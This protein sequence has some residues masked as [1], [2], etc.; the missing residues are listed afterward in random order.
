MMANGRMKWM[1]KN[2]VRVGSLIE[3]PPHNHVVKIVPIYGTAVSR[4]VI[5]VAAQNDICPHGST[6]PKKAVAIRVI[7]RT[8]PDSHTFLLRY[9]P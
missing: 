8:V 4:L 6:Y 3:K 7:S 5:T 2:R 9:E 1:A